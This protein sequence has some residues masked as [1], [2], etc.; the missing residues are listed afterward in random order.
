MTIAI[1]VAEPSI[2]NALSSSSIELNIQALIFLAFI[3]LL[4]LENQLGF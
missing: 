4:S 2:L 1:R 3:V